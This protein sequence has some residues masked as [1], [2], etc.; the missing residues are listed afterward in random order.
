MSITLRF[1]DNDQCYRLKVLKVFSFVKLTDDELKNK[2]LE[3]GKSISN[4]K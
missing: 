2:Q 4:L 3:Q 1:F